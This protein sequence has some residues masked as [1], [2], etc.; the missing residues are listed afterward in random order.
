MCLQVSILLSLGLEACQLF[1]HLIL[2]HF[3][4]LFFLVFE[5]VFDGLEGLNDPLFLFLE[6]VLDPFFMLVKE[7]VRY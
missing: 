7:L 4:E 3:N 1:L 6:L 5:L 2:H